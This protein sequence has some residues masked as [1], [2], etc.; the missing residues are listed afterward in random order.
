MK[1]DFG[2][3]RCINPNWP[4]VRRG[5]ATRNRDQQ[6]AFAIGL[7]GAVRLLSQDNVT[8]PQFDPRPESN[9]NVLFKKNNDTNTIEAIRSDTPMVP[10]SLSGLTVGQNA[11]D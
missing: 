11:Q 7:A 3:V 6:A 10:L 1:Q 8:L 2:A 4:G 5:Y 9:D